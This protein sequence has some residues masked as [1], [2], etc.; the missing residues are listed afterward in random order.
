MMDFKRC[1]IILIRLYLLSIFQF[2]SCKT[3]FDP[4][5]TLVDIPD[6]LITSTRDGNEEIYRTHKSK[7]SFENFTKH[8]DYDY[9]ADY[10]KINKK[11]IFIS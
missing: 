10:C 6:I 2:F 9:S 7:H 5:E 11:I 4:V 8:W 1:L 3:V